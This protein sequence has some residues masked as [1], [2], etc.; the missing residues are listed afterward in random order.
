MVRR[1][2]EFDDE[3]LD[4]VDPEFRVRLMEF[5]ESQRIA[6]KGGARQPAPPPDFRPVRTEAQERELVAGQAS[7]LSYPGIVVGKLPDLFA[8]RGS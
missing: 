2:I 3:D 8:K 4:S 1:T 6:R 7:P 5:E